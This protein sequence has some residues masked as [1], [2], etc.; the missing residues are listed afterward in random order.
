MKRR[1]PAIFILVLVIFVFVLSTQEKKINGILQTNYNDITKIVFFNDRT[2]RKVTVEN[3]EKVKEF[4]GLVDSYVLKKMSGTTEVKPG[5]AYSV[6]FYKGD[7]MAF[8]LQF[9]SLEPNSNL[10]INGK[11]YRVVKTDLTVEK[12][13]DFLK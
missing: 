12:I 3:K 9:I 2:G 11:E 8:T 13:D 10:G 7:K 1:L 4:M 6:Q 5:T